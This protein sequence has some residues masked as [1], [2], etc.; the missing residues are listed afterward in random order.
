MDEG[1]WRYGVPVLAVM[2]GPAALWAVFLI[3]R[4]LYYTHWVTV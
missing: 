1:H 3:G 2:F 4:I